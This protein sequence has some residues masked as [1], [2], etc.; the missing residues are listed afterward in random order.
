MRRDYASLHVHSEFSNIKVIDST[1]RFKRSID[2]AWDLGLS[3]VAMTDHD[4]VSGAIKY[5][6]FPI[7]F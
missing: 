6:R 2:Y 7:P 1:N 5:I 4:C 3:S